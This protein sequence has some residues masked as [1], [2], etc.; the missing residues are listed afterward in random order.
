MQKVFLCKCK[1]RKTA[2]S[3]KRELEMACVP[4]CWS[5]R[6]SY[7]PPFN[8]TMT[9]LNRCHSVVP[10]TFN[11]N[12]RLNLKQINENALTFCISTSFQITFNNF[13]WFQQLS[14]VVRLSKTLFEASYLLEENIRNT[15]KSN[16]NSQINLHN[17]QGVPTAP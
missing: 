10:C 9:F 2:I 1:Y 12:L 6:N 7:S 3:N 8:L 16:S 5:K 14:A 13:Q 15:R 17:F 11:K 4:I